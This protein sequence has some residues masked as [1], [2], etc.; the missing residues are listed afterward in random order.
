MF[1]G[2]LWA[3]W[4]PTK[5]LFVFRLKSLMVALLSLAKAQGTLYPLTVFLLI[6][7]ATSYEEKIHF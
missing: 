4:L 3:F 7:S 2:T 6:S 5:S 1:C